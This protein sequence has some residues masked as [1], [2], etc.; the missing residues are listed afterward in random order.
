MM[1][2]MKTMLKGRLVTLR[3]IEKEQLPQFQA[4]FSQYELARV[5]NPGT[6]RLPNAE[7]EEAWYRDFVLTGGAHVF[8]IFVND[9]SARAPRLVGSCSLQQID[10]KNRR[11]MCGIAIG[12]PEARGMG[13]GSEALRLLIEWGFLELNLNRIALMVLELNPDARRLYDRLGFKLEGTAR[14]A[15]FREGRFWDEHSMAIL[16]EDYTPDELWGLATPRGASA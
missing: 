7:G 6:V 8:A 15:V 5:M 10:H 14:Q 13:Y 11:A 9:P 3:P 1:S 12:A 16:R 2:T 4:W